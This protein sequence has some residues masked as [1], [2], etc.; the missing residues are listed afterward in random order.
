M[1]MRFAIGQF[2]LLPMAKILLPTGGGKSLCMYLVPLSLSSEAI[3]IVISPLI[4]LMDQQV[5]TCNNSGNHTWR[6]RWLS[7]VLL[8]CQLSMAVT[9]V[10]LKITCW[11]IL[12]L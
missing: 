5:N 12:S 2:L 10:I 7:L 6:N 9:P 1:C 11:K 8:A 3:G 4:C